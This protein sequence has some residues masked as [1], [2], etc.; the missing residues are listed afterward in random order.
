M[1][2]DFGDLTDLTPWIRLQQNQNNFERLKQFLP[3]SDSDE[4]TRL[5]S[6]REYRG[7]RG[8]GQIKSGTTC[9]GTAATVLTP[10]L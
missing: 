4:F 9:V 2:G 3:S 8:K 6:R 1:C 7:R 10:T 5:S